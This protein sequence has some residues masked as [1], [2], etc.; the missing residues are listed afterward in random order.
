M[1]KF[2]K[3]SNGLWFNERLEN[4]VLKRKEYSKSRSKNRLS[5]DDTSKTYVKHME[6]RNRNEDLSGYKRPIIEMG[7]KAEKFV[8]INPKNPNDAIIKVYGVDGMNKIYH[9]NNSLISRPEFIERYLNNRHGKPLND[10]RHLF[11]DFNLFV[12]DQFK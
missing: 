5:K 10:F 12:K 7:D 6:D 9:T 8:V 11:S 1:N 3:D 4:E 2:V